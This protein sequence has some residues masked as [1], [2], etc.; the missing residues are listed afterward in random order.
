ME[1]YRT[2]V[3]SANLTPQCHVPFPNI[4]NF[5]I[6]A[7]RQRSQPTPLTLRHVSICEVSSS[8]S[9][10]TCWMLVHAY[11]TSSGKAQGSGP[12]Q[13][14]GE[15]SELKFH[16]VMCYTNSIVSLIHVNITKTL[17]YHVHFCCQGCDTTEFRVYLLLR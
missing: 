4:T 12:H 16:N 11:A 9:Y 2:D 14:K 3:R 6:D 7:N 17:R 5:V 8:S 1:P 13:R 15:E 10:A